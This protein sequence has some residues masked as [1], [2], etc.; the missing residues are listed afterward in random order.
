MHASILACNYCNR[1]QFN[2]CWDQKV[3]NVYAAMVM[4][5]LYN[6]SDNNANLTMKIIVWPNGKEKQS[7]ILP[8]VAKGSMVSLHQ[9]KLHQCKIPPEFSS[10]FSP[11]MKATL[12]Q[13]I[14]NLGSNDN[15]PTQVTLYAIKMV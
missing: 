5:I 15:M 6:S 3:S 2:K 13:K 11:K 4:P 12:K 8:W 14:L 9:A 7:G 1:K 10:N